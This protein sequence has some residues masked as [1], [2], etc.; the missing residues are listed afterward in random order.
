MNDHN[1]TQF[2][3]PSLLKDVPQTPTITSTSY[4]VEADPTSNTA[5]AVLTA[6]LPRSS[7]QKTKLSDYKLT[8]TGKKYLFA[9]TP[10]GKTLLDNIGTNYIP[11]V[12][13][14]FMEQQSVKAAFK[15]EYLVYLL[16]KNSNAKL[17]G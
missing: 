16:I 7:H 5:E 15:Q 14:C 6:E 9:D 2:D 10:L 13:Y 11:I 4:E 17:H 1:N 3:E 12:K 8:F